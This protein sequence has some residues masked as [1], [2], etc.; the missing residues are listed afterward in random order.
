M[1]EQSKL[2]TRVLF[3]TSSASSKVGADESRPER[4]VTCLLEALGASPVAPWMKTSDK[5]TPLWGSPDTRVL[6]MSVSLVGMS[7]MENH[8][9]RLSARLKLVVEHTKLFS[10]SERCLPLAAISSLAVY[11]GLLS[12]RKLSRIETKQSISYALL[13]ATAQT[14]CGLT[15]PPWNCPLLNSKHAD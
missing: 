14:N 3:Q 11:V 7:Y 15:T 4:R 1:G 10:A 5:A 8:S 2:Q 12:S 9:W 6:V 13:N